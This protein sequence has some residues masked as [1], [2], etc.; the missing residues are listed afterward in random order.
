VCGDT[1]SC[2]FKATTAAAA[3]RFRAKGTSNP[4]TTTTR[5]PPNKKHSISVNHA[6]LPPCP[7]HRQP[8]QDRKEVSTSKKI[9]KCHNLSFS[10]RREG[11]K[12]NGEREKKSQKR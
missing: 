5:K 10:N 11:K 6:P 2:N 8:P 12:Q 7:A 9:K 3:T 4:K 1:T